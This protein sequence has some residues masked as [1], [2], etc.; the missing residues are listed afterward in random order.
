MAGSGRGVAGTP[1]GARR[2][3]SPPP[4]PR[5]SAAQRGPRSAPPPPRDA[6]L[7]R[8]TALPAQLAAPSTGLW[9]QAAQLEAAAPL[10]AG[11][12]ADLRNLAFG[13]TAESTRRRYTGIFNAYTAFA[14]Q[15]GIPEPWLPASE[16]KLA[17]FL[18]SL[19]RA[20]RAQSTVMVTASALA[21]A[22]VVSGYPDPFLASAALRMIV[23]GAARANARPPRSAEHL[24]LEDYRAAVSAASQRQTRQGT[25]LAL[26]LALA[27]GAFLRFSELRSLR[28]SDLVVRSD[29]LIVLASRSKTMKDGASDACPLP[30]TQDAWCP[31]R[32]AAAYAALFGVVLP[33]GSAHTLWPDLSRGAAAFD[34]SRGV[35]DAYCYEALRGL[36]LDIGLDGQLYSWHSLRSGAATAADE[37][38]LS[39]HV[40]GTMGAWSSS[41][42]QR[43]MRVPEDRR[44]EAVATMM[45]QP[46][47]P[48][49]LRRETPSERGGSGDDQEPA[50]KSRRL[51]PPAP[52][53]AF[54][55]ASAQASLP[56]SRPPPPRAAS[57]IRFPVMTPFAPRL[58]PASYSTPFRASASGSNLHRF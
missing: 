12:G 48:A 57:A 56:Q 11:L 24:T 27:F 43:Y 25:Q 33:H 50:A 7:G 22:H 8:A 41:T 21:W 53:S 58:A 42:V 32:L 35:S 5:P 28:W 31:L 2:Q 3:T 15:Q 20:G 1:R 40:I 49:P 19:A 39:Q 36:L 38:G 9:A 16:A 17:S 18:S 4:P 26:M 34:W 10:L 47:R 52:L 44:L 45:R 37:A 46:A 55:A 29:R 51:S 23:S 6:T 13:S 30:A 54:Q 14:R